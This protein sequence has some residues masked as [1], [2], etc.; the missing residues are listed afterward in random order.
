MQL[1][2]D[3]LLF[4]CSDY[5]FKK[6]STLRNSL[7][8]GLGTTGT[9]PGSRSPYPNGRRAPAGRVGTEFVGSSRSAFC[10]PTGDGELWSR[11]KCVFVTVRDARVKPPRALDTST[12]R[13]LATQT[14]NK[15]RATRSS[16]DGRRV[17][18]TLTY[19]RMRRTLVSGKFGAG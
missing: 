19:H 1:R 9:S 11:R 4:F 14:A 5:F 7:S 12:I 3:F 13:V 16:P 8:N 18:C 17:L 2:S 6:R 15:R 10:I